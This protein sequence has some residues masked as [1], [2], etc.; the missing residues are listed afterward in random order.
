MLY[1]KILLNSDFVFTPK[2]IA[3]ICKGNMKLGGRIIVIRAT[4]GLNLHLDLL[5]VCH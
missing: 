2:G 4:P 3:V 5:L 1:V